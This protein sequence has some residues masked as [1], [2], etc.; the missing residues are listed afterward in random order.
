MKFSRHDI[1]R[2]AF[3]PSH[4][5]PLGARS[6]G[7]YHVGSGFSADVR[8]RPFTQLFWS[9]EGEGAFILD[10]DERTL[11]PGHL[12]VYFPNMA[13]KFR[14]LSGS[15][16]YRYWT[17]DG[18][19]AMPVVAAFGFARLGI[20][21]AGPPPHELFDE[22]E[23]AVQDNTPFGERLASAIAYR[24]LAVAASGSF[25]RRQEDSLMERA[26]EAI[27]KDWMRPDFCVGSL[28][29]A[30]GLDRSVFSRRFHATMG[31][32][33]MG[34]IMNLRIQ[35][36]LSLLKNA[37]ASVA[38][39]ARACGWSDPNYFSRCIRKAT[40]QSPLEFMRG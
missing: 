24:L 29:D 33:P 28:A 34:Y 31:L 32:S 21:K 10:G 7:R 27:H 1:F 12:T 13:H 35:N 22:L 5:I 9:S 17:L 18:P 19:L 14:S 37:E 2:P 40:G 15:W 4:G 6:V 11:P 38:Q 8:G 36:A 26:L 20:Y 23:K 39:T 25:Q 3:T 16:R 30:V